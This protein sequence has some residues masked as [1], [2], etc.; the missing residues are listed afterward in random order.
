LTG[1]VELALEVDA[2][3]NLKNIKI[4]TEQP[5]YLN[6]GQAALSDFNGAKFIPAFRNGKPVESKVTIPIYY[7]PSG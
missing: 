3:G 4:V 1:V 5:P 2:A 7:K 6:F